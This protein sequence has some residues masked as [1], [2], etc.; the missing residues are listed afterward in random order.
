MKAKVMA[1]ACL[2]LILLLSIAT[3]SAEG[4]NNNFRWS[5]TQEGGSAG[6]S[7]PGGNGENESESNTYRLQYQERVETISRNRLRIAELGIQVRKEALQVREQIRRLQEEPGK[8]TEED[9]ARF[10][11]GLR[12]INTSRRELGKTLGEVSR[13]AYRL[14]QNR[15]QRNFSACL[16]DL[17]G[18]ISVQQARIRILNKLLTDMENLQAQL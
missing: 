18:I 4:G 8:L 17:D 5:G 14:R 13:Y 1:A 2:A 16:E 7:G 11:E 15:M 10:R 12:L 6:G 9:L 3:V